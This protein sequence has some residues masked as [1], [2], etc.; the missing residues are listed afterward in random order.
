MSHRKEESRRFHQDLCSLL[1]MRVREGGESIAGVCY[2]AG[3][4]EFG[5]E[6]VKI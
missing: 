2:R 5:E 4:I 1:A 3:E 6:E